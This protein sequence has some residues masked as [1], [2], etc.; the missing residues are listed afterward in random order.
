MITSCAGSY[1]PYFIAVRS[2]NVQNNTM[3][4]VPPLPITFHHFVCC[5]ALFSGWQ[6]AFAEPCDLAHSCSAQDYAAEDAISM[7]EPSPDFAEAIVDP[8]PQGPR[9]FAAAMAIAPAG[10]QPSGA[11]SGRVIFTAGGHGWTY[12]NGGSGI[13]RWY[14]QRGVTQEMN[15]DYGNMD[16]TTLFAFYCFNAGATVVPIRPVGHQ[17]NEVVLD[18]DDAA[19]TFA[20]TWANSSSTIFFGSAGDL[21][22]KY[23]SLAV[24]ETATAT[25]TPNIPKAGFYPVYTWVR[26]GSDRTYQL[27]RINHTGGQSTVRIPHHMVGNG[28]VY[29]GTYYFDAGSDAAKGSVVISNL[30]PSP[31]VGSVVIADAIRFGN[32]MGDIVPTPN[33]TEATAKS[34][35]PREEECAR[36]WVQK[37]LGQGQSSTIYNSSSDDGNDNVGTPPRM[38]R[39]MNRSEEQNRYKRVYVGF[40]SNAG[41]GRG[42]VGLYNNESLFPGTSTSTN[43]QRLAYL[44]SAEVDSDMKTLPLEFSWSSRSSLSYARSDYAFGEIRGDSIGYEMDATIIEVAF[45]DEASDA[46]LLRDCK[47]RNWMARA[48][49]QG[50]LRYMSEFDAAPLT[51]LPEPPSNVRAIATTNGITIS[52]AT[53][54]S[55]GG[56]AANYV[57]YRSSDGYGFGNPVAVSGGSTTSVT[58]TNLPVDTDFYFRVAA[59]NAGGESMPSETVGCRRSSSNA[60]PKILFVNAF[61]RFDRFTNLRQTPSVSNWDDPDSTGTMERMIPRTVNSFDYVVQHGKAIAAAGARFDSCHR[62]A[63]SGNQVSLTNYSI[64]IWESGQELTNTFS[65]TIQSRITTFLN[66][67]GGL[68]VSGSEIAGNLDRA[69]GPSAADRAFFNNQ[70]HADLASDA[71]TNSQSYSFSAASTSIFDGNA[72]GTFD[73]GSKGIYWV[74]SPS[75]LTPNGTGT[76]AAINYSGG[77]GGAAAIQYDGSAGGGRVVYIGFPFETVSSATV[78]NQYMADVLNFLAPSAPIITLQPQSLSVNAGGS[79]AFNVGAA[80]ATP[81]SYQWFFNGTI[82]AGSTNTSY[83]RVNVQ[84]A[85]TGNYFVVVSN[86]VGVVTSAVATLTLNVAPSITAQPQEA[87]AV[88]GSTASFSVGASGTAPLIYQ[89]RKAGANLAN[90]GNVSGATSAT[91]ALSN[92]NA[93]DAA[94]YSVVVSNAAGAVTSSAAALTVIAPPSARTLNVPPR[95]ANA[96]TG[97]EFNNIITPLS[98]T[99]REN[100]IYA[101]IAQGN[102]PNFMRNLVAVTTNS[103]INGTNF[104]VTF[105]VTPDYLAIGTDADYFLQPMT[106]ILGQRLSRLLNCSMPTRKMVNNIWTAATVKLAPSTIPPSGAMTTVPVFAQHNTT[107][108]NQRDAN[109]TP[110]GALVGGDKKD[111]VI[112]RNIYTNLHAGFPKPV[113]IY[114]WHQL[115]GSAIQPLYNGHEETYADYSHGI[116]MVDNAVTVNS[117]ATT[118]AQILNHATLSALLSDEGVIPVPEYP[119]T[120]SAP[121]ILTQPRSLMLAVGPPAVFSAT[122]FGDSPLSFTWT[123]NGSPVAGATAATFTISNPQVAD[124]GTYTLIVSNSVGSATS[125]PA[126]LQVQATTDTILFSDDFDV[127]SSLNWNVFQG[128]ANGIADYTADWAYNYGATRYTFNGTSY[129]I[130]PAPNSDGTTRGVRLT[131]NNND[132]NAATAAVNIYPKNYSFGSNHVLKFDMWINY[133]GDAGGI[134]SVG[135]TEHA[136]FGINHLGTQVN[137]AP[138]SAASSDGVWF[139]AT[140]E[141]GTS[142]D[143]RAYVG[144]LAGTQTELIGS[145]ASGLAE[146]NNASGIFPT[147]FPSSRFESAGAPGKNWVSVE[148][149]QTNGVVFWKFNG[150]TIVTRVN[151][152]AFASGNIMLGL[153]DAFSSIADPA[154]DTF[155]LFDNV[156]VADLGGAASEPPAIA[157][158]PQNRVVTQGASAAFSVTATGNAP[159]SYQWR[160]N[161]TNIS[162]ATLSSYTR[163]N[164]QP[165]H[166]GDYETVVSNGIGSITSQTAT[167]TVN[168]PPTITTQPQNQTVVQSATASFS[169][170]AA[171]TAPLGYQWKFGAQNISGATQSTYTINNA[172]SAAAGSYSVVISNV[173]GAMT[174]SVVSLVVNVPPIIS[175]HPQSGTRAA[176]DSVVLSVT[177]NGTA[178]LVYRWKKGGLDVVN[179][180]NVSGAT[181]PNLSLSNLGEQDA[182]AYSVIISNVAGIVTSG[183]ATLTVVSPPT[184][185]AQPPDLA[186]NFG[187][188]ASFEVSAAGPDLTYQ[189]RRGGEDLVDAGNVSGATT[190]SLT[191]SNVTQEDAALYSVVIT[192]LAGT[193]TSRDAVLT[194]NDPVILVQ[195]STRT[196]TS[197]TIA[198]FSVNATGTAP[199]RFQWRRN[200]SNLFDV[201]DIS[202][203]TTP[204]LTIA[205]ASQ[206]HA[207]QYSVIVA[208]DENAVISSNAL[209]V[210][211]GPLDPYLPSTTIVRPVNNSRFITPSTNFTGTARDL[212]PGSI[213][214]VRYRLAPTTTYV[215]ASM[216]TL[217]GVTTWTTPTLP[218]VPGTNRFSVYSIDAGGNQSAIVTSTFFYD[219]TNMLTVKINGKGQVKTTAI[220]SINNDQQLPLLV[221]RPY[222]LTAFIG[223][224]TNHVFTNWTN[225]D[226]EQVSLNPAYTFVMQSNLVLQANFITNPFTAV[227]GIYNGLFY[228][229]NEV[230]HES[231]GFFTMNVTR[232]G[233]YSGKLSLDGDTV[234]FG[235]KFNL[236]GQSTTN[237]S[238]AAKGKVNLYLN[239]ALDWNTDSE[240]IFG[241]LSDG[242]WSAEMLADRATFN[243][244]NPATNFVGSYTFL[245]PRTNH[246]AVSPGGI[247]YGLVTNNALGKVALLVSGLGDGSSIGQNVPISKRGQWPLFVPLYKNFYV[248]TNL[249][250]GTLATNRTYPR[251]SLL[252]WITFTNAAPTGKVSWIKTGSATN[253][254]YLGGFTNVVEIIGSPYVAPGTGVRMLNITNGTTTFSDGNVVGTNSWDVTW[255]TNNLVKPTSTASTKPTFTLTPKT[256]LLKGTFFHPGLGRMVPFSGAV[257]QW[258][259]YAVGYFVGT[260][261]SG[262]IMLQKK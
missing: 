73:D 241:R 21:A 137:W 152:S 208:N 237:I 202:G 12:G 64:L 107:V 123:R 6:I 218:L 196:N 49:Y 136:M 165:A 154:E 33:T 5:F 74:K 142:R 157:S 158:H 144:N 228:E 17:T 197:G 131:V 145:S 246:P 37:G 120:P 89:W 69:T 9:T 141:G 140:G 26:H 50:V 31:T 134:N 97:S 256:G 135:S 236:S 54:G 147:V 115:N 167:L 207:A 230:A 4:Q 164:A 25:Y 43:Q 238:R 96:P 245:V 211:A 189:W 112:S 104:T 116:R 126:L 232:K 156:R 213:V 252:G 7:F 63:I 85:T 257:L 72:N 184:I 249:L 111:V 205:A 47:V 178:P 159:L 258:Q 121:K 95:A 259:N 24:S 100:M 254:L 179:G 108:G 79:A 61:T 8:A 166:A 146:S 185:V 19:V 226:L 122:V 212:A 219:V 98:L 46:K 195:P 87:S 209:L 243:A 34:N 206:A 80:G 170:I 14:T 133:P 23:A 225:G 22:Y 75:V 40:H 52:W 163:A 1:F 59:V 210:I 42:C 180:G 102:V 248:Y 188:A 175:G 253:L 250:K 222:V 190:C 227:A 29:L 71:N 240:Q 214:D 118:I 51:F 13:A 155:V 94:A 132:T 36:Y 92:V 130:P 234:S 200:G 28:W 242:V 86:G 129:M 84:V 70:L 27:Y 91:L 235:G 106:P 201:G 20:G 181:S 77:I 260:N 162:G 193:V 2:K 220:P 169:V 160:F 101:Q 125:I 103:V 10:T 150:T 81:L 223:L 247:G 224:G 261:Q 221:G 110:L 177:A 251:G 88:Q 171:G 216:A 11:L 255:A 215:S 76:K 204:T 90:G 194:I 198:T 233:G 153:M 183:T 168:V 48:T 45:H 41:G 149:G 82:I 99:E 66:A 16:H 128:S 38:A 32:G 44:V 67:G 239:L 58:I 199:L 172:Q 60:L 203:A 109:G 173:A 93:T 127:D 105:Y 62:D 39:E 151:S 18:N 30:Q 57:V 55:G 148:V 3:S 83:T 187:S 192:N 229:T 119:L 114:G 68:F 143:Y 244:A 217:N 138:A 65:S 186:A 161:G 113:V 56:T 78:R 182:G 117:S 124:A 231:S 174:S 176:G 191:V 262:M 53:P 15:E 139:G 35:Y